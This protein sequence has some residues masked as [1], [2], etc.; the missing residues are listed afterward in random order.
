VRNTEKTCKPKIH[1]VVLSIHR[2]HQV[3]I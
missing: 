3:Y 1:G 2:P